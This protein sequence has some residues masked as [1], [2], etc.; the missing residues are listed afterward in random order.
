MASASGIPQGYVLLSRSTTH[1]GVDRGSVPFS[2]AKPG[3]AVPDKGLGLASGSCSVVAVLK[4]VNPPI[5][6]TSTP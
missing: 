1:R 5:V 6:T 2:E 4:P 3:H